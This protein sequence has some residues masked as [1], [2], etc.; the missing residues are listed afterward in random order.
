MN[1]RGSSANW[2]NEPDTPSTSK[3]QDNYE[4]GGYQL[5][6]KQNILN[7]NNL[8]NTKKNLNFNAFGS[9]I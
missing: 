5:E 7:E 4:I 2:K 8:T 1:D 9:N 6:L 3:K